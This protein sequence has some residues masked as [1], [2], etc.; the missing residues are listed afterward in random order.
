MSS[1]SAVAAVVAA[2]ESSLV[3]RWVSASSHEEAAL[4]SLREIELGFGAF[5]A[6]GRLVV[7]GGGILRRVEEFYH[8]RV[9]GE[10]RPSSSRF[11][12]RFKRRFYEVMSGAA[13]RK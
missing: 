1:S 8:K 3:W 10:R 5:E 12:L 6:E 2:D 4:D 13:T 9:K 7:G 11:T